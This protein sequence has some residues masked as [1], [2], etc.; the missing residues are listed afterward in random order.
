MT[1]V[2]RFKKSLTVLLAALMVFTILPGGLLKAEA[3]EG[4]KTT[5][6]ISNGS[7]VIGNGTVEQNGVSL[8]YNSH[9]YIITGSDTS[10]NT[11]TVTGG[12]QDITLSGV[13]I[14]V[15]NI[16]VSNL[17][18]GN[19]YYG[20]C[21]CAFS[22]SSGASVNLALGD[23]NTLK[24]G[25]GRA[26]LE[27]P[28]GALVSIAG[29]GSLTAVGGN[30]DDM[31]SSG[32]GIGSGYSAGCGI[33]NISGGTVT[34]TGGS[35]DF[36]G[37]SGGAG[38]GGGYKGSGGIITISG[39]T[40]TAIGGS[41]EV[42]GGGA[43]IGSGNGGLSNGAGVSSG[44]VT[45]S[46]G[47][48]TATG[49]N[50]G[51]GIGGGAN[52]SGGNVTISGGTVT[53]NA[54]VDYGSGG[55]VGGA[56]I[57]GGECG[58]GGSTIISG[59]TVVANGGSGGAGI[60]CGALSSGSSTVITGGSVYATS[61]TGDVTDGS[62]NTEHCVTVT[63]LT[64]TADV[65]ASINGGK[66]F[67]CKTDGSSQLYLWMAAGNNKS[68]I[69]CN[70]TYYGANATDSDTSTAAGEM[71][72][73]DISQGDI[74]IADSSLTGKDSKGGNASA[75]QYG[76]VIEESF[77]VGMRSISV[78]SGMQNIVLKSFTLNDTNTGKCP[79]SI[80]GS[81]TVYLTLSGE[82][83]LTGDSNYAGIE[84]ASTATLC[85]TGTDAD[86]LYAKSCGYGAG[87]GGDK[88]SIDCGTVTIAGGKI[89]AVGGL[90]GAGI[91]GGYISGTTG[92][93][94]G[95][96]TISGGTVEASGNS[97]SAGIGGGYY[98]NGAEVTI[99]GGTV[100]AT[101]GGGAGI[102]GGCNGRGVKA[103]ISGGYITATGANGGA[104]IGGG[105]NKKGGEIVIS[106]GTV[107]TKVI[108]GAY[109]YSSGIGS[110][111]DGSYDT[112]GTTTVKITG[113]SVSTSNIS[114]TPTSDGTTPV[115]PTTVTLPSG[116]DVSA[117][118]ITQSGSYSYGF[119]GMQADSNEMLYLYL[120]AYTDGDTT[121]SVTADGT[122]YNGYHGTV[123][124]SG[125]QASPNVLKMNQST[126]GFKN[127]GKQVFTYGYTIS[128][129][130]AV[131]GG[132]LTGAVSY[133]YSGTDK[134]GNTYTADTACPANAGNGDYTITATLPGNSCYYDATA[135]KAFIVSQKSISTSEMAVAVAS[136]TYT[137]AAFSPAITAT[138]GS[139]TL[140]GG[141]DYE[142]Y[143]GTGGTKNPTYTNAG[144]Y[145]IMVKGTG[146]YTGS[147]TKAFAV[148]QKAI[149]LTLAA[150]QS[151]A[152]AG[153]SVNLTATV[154]SGAV[155]LPGGTVTFKYGG[156]TIA[157]G[158]NITESDGKYTAQ[159]PWSNVPAGEYN[160]TA[161]YAP[162]DND[163]Y[164]CSIAASIG[165]YSITKYDQ[166]GF[167]F[168][169][170]TIS[171]TY[172]DD[173]FT[174]AASGGQ[175]SGNVTYQS[176]D[177]DV[178]TVTNGGVVTIKSAGTVTISAKKAS[179]STYNEAMDTVTVNIGKAA[180]FIKKVP[181]ASD[182]SVVG[183]LSSV[184]LK[185]GEGSV[186]GS[187]GWTNP[188]MVVS[189]NGEYE[190]TFTP[191][192]SNYS[193][194]ICKVQVE[195]TPV[196]TNSGTG[197][198]YDLSGAN[199]PGGV[200]SVSVHSSAVSEAGSGS[201][202][203]SVVNKLID[204]STSSASPSAVM[205]YNLSL[206]DQG[207]QAVTGFTG[208]ITVKIPIPSGMS[209]DLHVYWYNDADGTVTDM[210]ARQ[211][212]GYLVFNTT[213]FSYYAVAELASKSMSDSNE[214]S[215]N[216]TS[217]TD[218]SSETTSNPNTGSDSF[219][220]LPIALLG[221]SGCGLV[222]VTRGRKFKKK[223]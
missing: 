147:V 70:D 29:T 135:T 103:T 12:T 137:G 85:I 82:N 90:Y 115:Y 110:G 184:E 57:G 96:V 202:A 34:A 49:S 75:N 53:A 45:I 150:S 119:T 118:S 42:F 165:G 198:Q 129:D 199:L 219:P 13:N 69:C 168:P 154:S 146:N 64:A 65:N 73:L 37:F 58:S 22:I 50:G 31:K 33:V 43:G 172:G 99:T 176:S 24:S 161:E 107:I 88:N 40:V 4:D 130:T 16:D 9:G 200:T 80:T 68:A 156:T 203:Y 207:N 173:A 223:N 153:G 148:M 204:G 195:V 52:V 17:S 28:E 121:V 108:G 101:A 169:D 54:G 60:G 134:L 220:F 210:N 113:G 159:T 7:I 21:P 77:S 30:S 171:K 145:S 10:S 1:S 11:I 41:D 117:L 131:T 183:K 8:T 116:T 38:I 162:A 106:G 179:D 182:I 215:S 197:V 177:T 56:G 218:S 74:T 136:A 149:A 84:V 205:I 191:A 196:I 48:V 72:V 178:A 71:T 105:Y 193:P 19:I 164:S 212:N 160:I 112:S 188:D 217:S 78:T 128:P 25:R 94:G 133:T 59:G 187:F 32:A 143:D 189:E 152:K 180:A 158:V 190:A 185:D 109:G 127:T 55:G 2:G 157:S 14:D 194:C 18:E 222:V 5:L 6:N 95:T 114:G 124:T 51:A 155:N 15:S 170:E 209:G 66:T 39:G 221:I 47:E 181:T 123:K 174:V 46:G 102:G 175:S 76:Y 166:T 87:I 83:T 192:S 26:G 61:I 100:T 214:S 20:V 67:F 163:N 98:G 151:E 63:G 62:G 93:S 104:G 141:T 79:M 44:S 125:T 120:P 132:T 86:S 140:I 122:A 97:C 27:V 211:E 142:V 126:F 36:G 138:F 139:N 23:T 144:S 111:K 206:M 91:G 92:G 35:G 216:N 81:A 208:K 186:T 3:A 167:G 213:H 201:S 89:T